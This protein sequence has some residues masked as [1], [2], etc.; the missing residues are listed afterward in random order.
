MCFQNFQISSKFQNPCLLIRIFDD[1]ADKE[2]DADAGIFNEETSLEEQPIYQNPCPEASER[3]PIAAPRVNQGLIRGESLCKVNGKDQFVTSSPKT[4]ETMP[5]TDP[6]DRLVHIDFKN[7]IFTF[8]RDRVESDVPSDGVSI[9]S[10]QLIKDYYLKKGS[11]P[12]T[13]NTGGLNE[14]TQSAPC[15]EKIGEGHTGDNNLQTQM[16]S[17]WTLNNASQ[18]S[19][20]TCHDAKDTFNA[21]TMNSINSLNSGH[22]RSLIRINEKLAEAHKY[23][24]RQPSPMVARTNFIPPI[25]IQEVEAE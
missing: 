25:A 11:L 19:I 23:R 2:K 20:D 24:N 3:A 9:N 8:N 1:G 14:R 12:T 22:K 6:T 16:T 10:A 18:A 15:A 17:V 7:Q 21:S 13:P 5:E 4:P